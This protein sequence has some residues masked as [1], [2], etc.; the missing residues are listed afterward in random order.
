M[1]VLITG[2]TGMIGAHF[3]NAVRER[4]WE[5]HGIA[6]SSA[7]SRLIG[8]DSA[9]IVRCDMTDH[10]ALRRL[11]GRTRFDLVVHMAAQAFNSYSWEVEDYTHHANYLGTQ[12]VLQ[13][14]RDYCPEAKVL[15]ACSSAEYG[16][17][18]PGECPIR[19]NRLLRP[20]S[21]YGVTKVAT[22]CLGY[23]F[24]KNYG[25]KVYL[26]RMFIHVGTG[27]PPATAIQNFARQIALI[28]KGMAE[29]VLKV[30]VL[31]TARDFIDVRD[32]VAG[33][34]L[35]LDKGTAGEPANICT[36]TAY[37]ISE[38]LDMLLEISGLRVDVVQDPTLLRPSDEAVLV[39][40]NS[41]LRKLGWKQRYT[42]RQ[43]LEAVYQDWL[44]RV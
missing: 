26:P 13:C 12:N 38:I 34:M 16:D 18:D 37:K 40:D 1:K 10:G 17:V 36:G 35:M 39:G 3:A 30:G 5:A 15:L 42:I 27:H 29:P 8:M 21:P 32:G 19:E 24:F 33:M 11:F 43:T 6:R 25:I 23:Q 2:I 14:V 9:G 28:A 41:R 7:A 44:G 20:I 4:G 31:T 22:E